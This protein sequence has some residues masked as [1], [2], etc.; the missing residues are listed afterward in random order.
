MDIST[1]PYDILPVLLFR[2]IVL[3]QLSIEYLV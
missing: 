3:I 2:A 1:H